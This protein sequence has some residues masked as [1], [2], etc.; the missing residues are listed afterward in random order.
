MGFRRSTVV[1]LAIALIAAN[2]SCSHYI[3]VPKDAYRDIDAGKAERWKVETDDRTVYLVSR[4]TVTDSTLVIE[5]FDASVKSPETTYP[6]ATKMP[7]TLD[8]DE[9]RSIDKWV[10]VSEADGL[11]VTAVAAVAI[12]MVL[13]IWLG[14][15]LEKNNSLD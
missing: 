11:L 14:H 10:A 2:W 12:V 9:V 13:L 7:Y 8:L 4:F 3:R 15:S 1:I 6:L 5:K